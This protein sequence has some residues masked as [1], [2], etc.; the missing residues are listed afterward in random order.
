MGRMSD[1][2]R[3][4][5]VRCYRP[6]AADPRWLPGSWTGGGIC[7][8]SGSGGASRCSPARGDGRRDGREGDQQEQDIDVFSVEAGK[9]DSLLREGDGRDQPIDGRMFRMRDGD[10]HPDAGRAEL[11][12]L[13]NR[14]DD[15]L[16]VFGA[17]A[18]AFPRLS[19]SAR[20]A[21]SLVVACNSGRIASLTTK[22]V[23]FI[24]C[25]FVHNHGAGRK[26]GNNRPAGFART[27]QRTDGIPLVG[28]RWPHRAAHSGSFC[29]CS[30]RLKE[31]RRRL[32]RHRTNAR[33]HAVLG[34]SLR[35]APPGILPEATVGVT[36]IQPAVFPPRQIR[37]SA[38][39]GDG[40]ESWP[41]IS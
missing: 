25:S 10:A 30:S 12:T 7:R 27:G 32:R 28:G 18:A 33:H 14:R 1:A 20:I 19:T 39:R 11:F 3:R 9:I 23:I 22:S 16:L 13:Q 38:H 29:G 26:R 37:S 40:L 8:S 36:L 17:D 24:K 35:C 6:R 4:S 2:A 41:Y 21:D 31:V 5:T 34:P 15:A